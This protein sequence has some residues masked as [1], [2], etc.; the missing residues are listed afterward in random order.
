VTQY[1][2]SNF[3]NVAP[4]LHSPLLSRPMITISAILNLVLFPCVTALRGA[5]FGG[6]VWHVS[7][8]PSIATAFV[9]L[10]VVDVGK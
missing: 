9:I 7:P 1:Y 5:A 6:H 4:G 10:T 8:S 2:C 3:H